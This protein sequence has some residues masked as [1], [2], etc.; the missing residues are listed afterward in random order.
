M[1]RFKLAFDGR[2]AQYR[3]HGVA[4]Y[5]SRLIKALSALSDTF[6]Y[7]FVIGTHLPTSH[8]D[9]PPESQFIYTTVAKNS[10]LRDFWEQIVLP[11]RPVE[12]ITAHTGQIGTTFGV[13]PCTPL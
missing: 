10:K 9:F 11:P 1:R 6:D 2:C 5:S 12:S 4:N 8:I 13:H 7:V 3:G